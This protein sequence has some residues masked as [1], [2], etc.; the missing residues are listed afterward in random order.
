MRRE[1]G[2]TV[3]TLTAYVCEPNDYPI[4]MKI[5]MTLGEWKQ[6]QEQ[7]GVGHPASEISRAI[8]SIVLN[9]SQEIE[10]KLER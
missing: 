1:G 9:L 10:K 7:M 5:R 2:E 4:E 8:N 3:I 6:L